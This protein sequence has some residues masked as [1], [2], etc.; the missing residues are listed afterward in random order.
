MT[1]TIVLRQL[2]LIRTDQLPDLAARWLAADMTD[3]PATLMLA[4]HNPR[5]PWK[6]DQL[7]AE[8]AAETRTTAPTDL[9]VL[10]EIAVDWVTATWEDNHDTRTAIATLARLGVTHPDFD[11]GLF[12]GLDDE[13][14]GGW[15]RLEPDLKA[16]AGQEIDHI[17]HGQR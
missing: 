10:Q 15:G 7:L 8:A 9:A 6:L 14:N 16:A 12:I 17:L 1:Q 4:G 2:G 5:D 13:W 11:L 3:T